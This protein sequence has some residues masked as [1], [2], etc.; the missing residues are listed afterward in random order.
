MG[1]L[2]RSSRWSLGP[3]WPI[4]DIGAILQGLYPWSCVILCSSTYVVW[5]DTP[6]G[7]LTNMQI[8]S[9]TRNST[10]INGSSGTY[11]VSAKDLAH[12][13][14]DHPYMGCLKLHIIETMQHCESVLTGQVDTDAKRRGRPN[15]LVQAIWQ[16]LLTLQQVPMVYLTVVFA[17]FQ[18]CC[19]DL[20]AA[21]PSAV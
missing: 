4:S 19:L 9:S 18:C 7:I 5:A 3:H 17:D 11:N 12:N 8:Q 10:M 16:D 21:W 1:G 2:A 14:A 13:H 6:L 15:T 20:Y